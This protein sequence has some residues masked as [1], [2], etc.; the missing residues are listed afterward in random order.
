MEIL[1]DDLRIR[2]S[3]EQFIFYSLIRELLKRADVEYKE[4]LRFHDTRKWRFDIG[5]P[6]HKVAFEYEGIFRGKS[7][8]T[9]PIGASKDCDKYNEATWLGW[10]VYRFTAYH[11]S[12]SQIEETK[13][14]LRT[15]IKILI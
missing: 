13:R 6:D 3:E 8:H 5:I 2:L 10:K 11:F 4:E 12:G 1:A 9:T 14:F 7:R 15:I